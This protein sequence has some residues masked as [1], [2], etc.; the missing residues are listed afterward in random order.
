MNLSPLQNQT[1]MWANP[2]IVIGQVKS[3]PLHL[4]ACPCKNLSAP[5]PTY[6]AQVIQ[7]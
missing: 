3:S 1:P 4:S 5:T 2:P 6:V 7:W